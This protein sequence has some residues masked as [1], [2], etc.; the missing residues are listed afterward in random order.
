MDNE[1]LNDQAIL[2]ECLLPKLMR[3]LF[4]L[5]QDHPVQELPLAQLRVCAILANGPK[6]MSAIG[7]EL[8]NS[9]SAITQLADRMERAGL[10][11]RGPGSD[12][13]RVRELRLT[14]EGAEM[15]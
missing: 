8:R 5:E 6:S 13:R 10:V 1:L 4:T 2:L 3:R 7:E 11:E 12:D 9:T 14:K 15:M